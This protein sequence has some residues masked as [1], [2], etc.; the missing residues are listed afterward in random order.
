M[1]KLINNSTM[2]RM[3]KFI[4]LM[5]FLPGLYPCSNAQEIRK[6]VL[7][8]LYQDT[9]LSNGLIGGEEVND[10]GAIFNISTAEI[11]VMLP[12]SEEPTSCIIMFPGG[13]YKF[14][15][16]I[17]AGFRGAEIFNKVNCSCGSWHRQTEWFAS[18]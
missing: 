7:P 13:A 5:L 17:E 8:V 14:V 18:L 11:T 10:A 3:N 1:R 4:L 15:N 16:I 6:I 9:P 2:V 12:A